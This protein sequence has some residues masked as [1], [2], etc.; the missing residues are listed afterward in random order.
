MAGE[1]CEAVGPGQH[2]AGLG[3]R[4]AA[5]AAR[6]VVRDRPGRNALQ[7]AAELVASAVLQIADQR[8]I[9]QAFGLEPCGGGEPVEGPARCVG[10]GQLDG[11]DERAPSVRAAFGRERVHPGEKARGVVRRGGVAIVARNRAG[12]PAARREHPVR[13][14]VHQHPLVEGRRFGIEAVEQH[15]GV[16]EQLAQVT[17]LARRQRQVVATRRAA[18][19]GML[20]PGGIA[21]PLGAGEHEMAA[22]SGSGELPRAAQACDAG[23]DDRDIHGLGGCGPP[24]GVGGRTGAPAFAKTVSHRLAGRVHDDRRGRPE[25]TA[26]ASAEGRCRAGG[27]RA[28]TDAQRVAAISAPRATSRHGSTAPAAACSASWARRRPGPCRAGR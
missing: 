17:G 24:L 28:E 7:G 27:E 8:R 1:R 16:R 18:H 15:A 5:A 26:R 11:H 14:R 10:R 2:R 9:A 3:I 23:A 25:R 6:E 4:R 12:L 22:M 20:A 19:A 21:Q 13:R